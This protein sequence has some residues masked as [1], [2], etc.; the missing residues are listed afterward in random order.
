MYVKGQGHQHWGPGTSM[1]Q[2]VRPGFVGGMSGACCSSCVSGGSCDSKKG[3]GLFDSGM[4]F[5]L[6]TWQEWMVVGLGG[7]MLT[8]M[9][10]GGKRAARAAGEGAKRGVKRARK[11]LA[12]KV[13][14]E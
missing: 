7:Y 4:D 11:R 12:A 2:M 14:G 3:M 8:S 1:V 9:F 6:W 13:A 10:F 5:T